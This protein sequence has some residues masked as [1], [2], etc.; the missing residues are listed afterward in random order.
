MKAIISEYLDE[1]LDTAEQDALAMRLKSDPQALREFTEAIMFDQQIRE[2][3]EA[4]AAVGGGNSFL[5]LESAPAHQAPKSHFKTLVIVAAA[6]ALLAVSLA[7]LRQSQSGENPVVTVTELTGSLS[8]I[9]TDGVALTSVSEGDSLPPGAFETL[10]EGSRAV[11]SF[12]DKSELTI[13]GNTNA[14]VNGGGQKTI[15]LAYGSIRADVTPQPADIPM[16]V[17]TSTA[18]VDVLGTVFSLNFSGEK[19]TMNVARGMVKFR[20]LADG[21]SVEVPANHSV[22]A[23]LAT[24]KP[25]EVSSNV[26]SDNSWSWAPSARQV[27]GILA[28][29]DD[30]KPI[31]KSVPAALHRDPETGKLIVHYGVAFNDPA[32]SGGPFVSVTP[33]SVLRFRYRFSIP[34]EIF[35]FIVTQKKS[36]D[37]GGN[38][39]AN[40]YQEAG[41]ETE[42]G[43]REVLIPLSKFR[44]VDPAPEP[45]PYG[46]EISCLSIRS[47]V[48]DTKLEFSEIS[49]LPSSP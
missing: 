9:G 49:I 41:I 38:F 42:D 29:T 40:L 16:V 32:G 45:D 26:V 13:T 35:V 31:L 14:T 46:H 23:S 27:E 36:G 48:E 37:F 20:R 33:E 4:N 22:T 10:G 30:G 15:R 2:A 43:W 11:L 19:T 25:L 39:K 18:R 7:F 17:L 5:P 21:D 6:I 12:K 28:N 47:F 1:S 34:S 8:W 24:S 3:V 44:P